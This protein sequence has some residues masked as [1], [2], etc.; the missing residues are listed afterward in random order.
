[1]SAQPRR[2]RRWL[3]GS[4]GVLALALGA[5]LIADRGQPHF[6]G[7]SVRAW[8]RQTY[9]SSDGSW[10]IGE[11]A[12]WYEARLAFLEMGT[13]A[14]PFLVREA[15]RF[16]RNSPLRTKLREVSKEMP[17]WAPRGAF[18]P[19][20][21]I[22]NQAVRLLRALE[23]PA[24][25]LVPLLQ[26]HFEST[27]ANR[28]VQANMLLGSVGEGADSVVPRLLE[29]VSHTTNRFARNAAWQSLRQIGV[30]DRKVLN[31]ILETG[32]SEQD[33]DFLFLGFVPWIGEFGPAGSPVLPI[34]EPWLSHTNFLH[35]IRS[36]LA[37]VAID[38]GH[39]NAWKV[40]AD[41]ASPDPNSPEAD[42]FIE[43]LCEAVSRSSPRSDQR[44]A[45]L[46]VPLAQ[47][48]LAAWNSQ[49]ASFRAINALQR[50]APET[51]RTLLEAQLARSDDSRIHAARILLT[52]DRNHTAAT[53][54]LIDAG[55]APRLDSLQ[56]L[57]EASSTNRLAIEALEAVVHGKDGPEPQFPSGSPQARAVE[58]A[59]AALAR[60]RYREAR[61]ARGLKDGDWR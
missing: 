35:R 60:I 54:T 9:R 4:L 50:V 46:L 20:H 36:A 3:L 51:T 40:L 52:L 28:F 17:E 1:M 53:K 11:T 32:R 42:K 14:V 26:P 45:N 34:L 22:Q 18:T 44:L 5:W 56:Y 24:S 19:Y 48:E 49:G 10:G 38:P 2:P 30:R 37:I 6:Q 31:A 15:F 8:F 12:S 39:S 61:E 13:N 55:A 7:R 16:R 59:K 29:T 27:D 47:R 25:V 23:P 21:E 33:P 57:G 43:G 41:A 58:Q